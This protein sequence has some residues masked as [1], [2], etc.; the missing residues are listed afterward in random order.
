MWHFYVYPIPAAPNLVAPGNNSYISDMFLLFDWDTVATANSF[1]IQV[2]VD[3]AFAA[4]VIDT[5]GL[6]VSNYLTQ[7]LGVLQN[8]TQYYWR[9]NASNSFATSLWS[10]RWTFQTLTILTNAGSNESKIPKVFKLYNNYPNPFNPATKIKFDLPSNC[11]VK[12]KIFDITGKEVAN[13]I[14][15]ELKA[16]TY[17]YQ[18]NAVNLS[19]GVYFYRI[20]TGNFSDIKRMM[21]IK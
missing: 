9:V 7:T 13:L 8:N 2:S 11:N 3:S 4:T 18:F 5:S 15:E 19:S 14:N 20:E 1:R 6:N 17:E 12:L 16:G 21:L 10:Q